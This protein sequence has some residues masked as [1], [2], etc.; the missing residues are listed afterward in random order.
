[1]KVMVLVLGAGAV[2]IVMVTTTTLLMIMFMMLTMNPLGNKCSRPTIKVR[3]F[4]YFFTLFTYLTQLI[5]MVLTASSS[6]ASSQ[7]SSKLSS[8]VHEA[9]RFSKVCTNNDL[10]FPWC[11][12]SIAYSKV[13]LSVSPKLFTSS[14][15]ITVYHANYSSAFAS[16]SFESCSR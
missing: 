7:L 5:V 15:T 1:M 10:H 12:G 8:P 16:L 4:P 14:L 3:F 11:I 9:R 2:S 6:P 13:P